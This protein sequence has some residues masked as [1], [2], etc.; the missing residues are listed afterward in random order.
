M[1]EE[2]SQ[3]LAEFVSLLT[4]HQSELLG[5][6]ISLMPGD[7]EVGDV[8]QK[9]NLVI[10]N[11]RAQFIPGSN[12]NAWAF[13]IARFEVLNHLRKQRRAR[14]A[15]LDD[16]LLDTIA[17]EA[18]AE[19]GGQDDMRLHA[20]EVCLSQMRPQDRELLEH[21]YRAGCSLQEFADRAGRSVSGLSVTLNRLRTALRFCIAK[22]LA[23]GGGSG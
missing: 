22:R 8:L 18:A 11:K 19:P 15:L 17:S 9:T 4:R 14:P 16:E 2:N 6:I 12:F 7:P 20:L 10:W 23:A 21:R 3:P 5:F 13:T 1:P